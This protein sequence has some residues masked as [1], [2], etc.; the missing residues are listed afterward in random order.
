M[1]LVGVGVQALVAPAY[2]DSS[3]FEVFCPD[4][5]LGANIVLNDATFTGTLSPSTPSPGQTFNLQN[6]QGNVVLPPSVAQTASSVPSV[7]GTWSVTVQAQGASPASLPAGALP[8][9]LSAPASPSSSVTLTT[10]PSPTTIGPLT[11]TSPNVALS[12]APTVEVT[13]DF[14]GT[15]YPTTCT[16]YPNDVL[17]SGITQALPPGAPISPVI[18]T[19]GQVTT[20]PPNPVT[21]PYE[22]YCP[23]TPVGDLVFNDVTTSA[24][25][26]PG[27]LSAGDSFSVTGYQT[28]IPVPAG[29]VNA[30]VGL[31]NTSFNGLAAS[32]VDLY[33][34]SPSQIATGQMGFDVPLTNPVPSSGLG[35][36][37]PSSPITVGPFTAGGGPIT[38][39]QDQ[40]T[41]VVAELSNKAFKMSC[42]A[43][44]NDSIATSGSTGTAPTATPIRPIIAVASASGSST[45]PPPPG[46]GTGPTTVSSGKPFELFCPGT[47]I[48]NLAINDTTISAS[49]SPSTLARGDHFQLANLQMAFSLPQSVVQQAENLGLSKLSGTI[50][51]FPI[52]T[53]AS[54][55]GVIYASGGSGSASGGGT[56]V[57]VPGPGPGPYP[58]P[59]PGPFDL[60]FDVTLPSPV[61]SNGVQFTATPVATNMP[62]F[63]ALGG[64][65]QIALRGVN[66]N[67][68][69]FGDRFGLFCNSYA[70]NSEPTGI[71]TSPPQGFVEAV[72]A[73]GSATIPPPPPP[74][75]GPYEV[76]C[77][78]TPVGSIALN[79][80]S[81]SGNLS[82]ASPSA[83]Q[84]FSLTGYQTQLVIPAS[85]ASA[86]AALGNV[87]ITGTAT[88]T[89]EA[90]G[91]TPASTS[92]SLSFSVPI[93]NPVPAAGLRLSVPSSPITVGPFKATGGGITISEASPISLNVVATGTDTA[94]PFNFSCESFPNNSDPSGITTI[95]P[96]GPPITPEIVSTGGTTPPPGGL[97]G[98]YELY[99]PGT[100]VGDIALNDAVTTGSISP[101][102]PSSGQ[103]FNITNYQT[104]VAL[105]SNIVRAA[106]ALGNTS[107]TGTADVALDATGATPAKI[108]SGTINFSVP[109]PS[110]VPP[111]GLQLQLPTPPDTIGPFT[112][113]GGPIT[114]TEDTHASVTIMVSG[115][116][117]ALTCTAYPNNTLPS[118]IVTSRPGVAP[119]SPV[120]ATNETAST[121]TAQITQA[122]N[123]LFDFADPSVAD[124]VAVIQDGASIEAG[125]SQALSSSL[126]TSATGAKV[127]NISFL[128]TSGCT[129]AMLPSPC[130][131]V[132]YDILGQSGTAI[133]PNNQ[134]YA[135]SINGSWLVATNTVCGLLGLFYQ[136]EG[137]TG[138]PP[139]CPAAASSTPTTIVTTGTGSGTDTTGT[140]PP[141]GA[142]APT[143][144]GPTAT[145]DVPATTV[146]ASA[147]TSQG[148]VTTAGAGSTTTAGAATKANGGS[149]SPSTADPVTASSGSLAFTGLG[150]VTWWLGV[151]GGALMLVGFALLVLVDIPRRLVFRIAQGGPER[152]HRGRAV[153]TSGQNE[154]APGEALWIS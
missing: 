42:T 10:P 102:S 136:A 50:S 111:S 35:I 38:V 116:S 90:S 132:T 143:N 87:S 115:S 95:P 71:V 134:G 15:N 135:V 44:P 13:F 122:Y 124:K 26:S 151:V 54:G 3:P 43:Y 106:A 28:H 36:D 99:C 138:N 7:T 52:T 68:T 66:I 23:H 85:I 5:L 47:P 21:G 73:S 103:Q 14:G 49:L 72:I 117:L 69:A 67:V 121:P 22:L 127:N 29:L 45:T 100:P 108:D 96:F 64:P 129:Q 128:D 48:G 152:R 16:S 131:S 83:G 110:P 130:A 109:I 93:P 79:D 70:H 62:S 65:I 147:S 82:P 51:L 98:P 94:P 145:T 139:G 46:S 4:N 75:P 55:G 107:I 80:V 19:A 154:T 12:L 142:S 126:A 125:L 11:A 86:A 39:A 149:S 146:A 57:I 153:A 53:G 61:P 114:I 104:I 2:A 24:S 8:F 84:Q 141:S 76:Y 150:G 91:A 137:K 60:S 74:G 30:A 33:G 63:F 101:A 120:F 17:P 112:S 27:S 32:S 113:S 148:S 25:V 123:T 119:V 9:T 58:Y 18:A 37:L 1:M 20:P 144:S 78:N 133:L 89:V 88:T 34:A 97:T 81:T 56:I 59:F 77:P 40:S 6:F 105:P 118:G 31:G 140:S 92:E 41:F